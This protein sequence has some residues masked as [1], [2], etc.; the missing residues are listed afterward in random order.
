MSK[1]IK[2]GVIGLITLV[3]MIWGFQFL[4]GKNLLRTNYAFEVVYSNVEGITVSSPVE[5]NGLQIGAI[6]SITVNPDDVRTMI[7]KFDVEGEH[8]LP[9]D[10]KALLSAGSIVGGKKIVLEFDNLCDGNNCL[11]NG[12]RLEGGSRGILETIVTKEEL[13]EFFSAVI[14]GV[15]P[16]VDTVMN[17]VLDNQADNTVSNSL[18]SLESSMNNLA[19]LTSNLDR[20]LKTSYSNLD[21][22]LGNM[23][24]VSE[25]FAKTN[26]DLET[27]IRNFSKFSTQLADSDLGETLEKTNET[28]DNANV[29]L[30]DLKTT[31]GEATTTFSKVNGLM[32]QVGEGDGTIAKL[33]N[34]PEIYNNLE[35]TSKHMSL[36][37]QDLRLNPKRYVRLSVF[38]RKGNQYAAP[39]EDPAFE[40]QI[41]EETIKEN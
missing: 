8:L 6:S 24:V 9:Q 37:L 41:P 23:A 7:V 17:T 30:K 1:E 5:I 19:S 28:F 27:M 20:L 35:A 4:K 31:V 33:L 22:T 10:A 29:L 36:L 26:D 3:A 38:G 25:S 12:A 15:G 34:D 39:E 2:I 14:K 13:K 21:Q 18:K 40:L 32:T 11:Q 16:V